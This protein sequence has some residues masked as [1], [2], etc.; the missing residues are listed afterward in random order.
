MTLRDRHIREDRLRQ[1]PVPRA[2]ACGRRSSRIA[3][4]VPW[5]RRVREFEWCEVAPATT[6]CGREW[7]RGIPLVTRRV[8]DRLSWPVRWQVEDRD[9]SG[10]L[11]PVGSMALRLPFHRTRTVAWAA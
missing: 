1:V 3:E 7:N 6:S 10:P 4:A 11:K 2:G 5:I 9:P 8:P